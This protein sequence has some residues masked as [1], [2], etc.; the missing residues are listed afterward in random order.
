M[1]IFDGLDAKTTVACRLE[2]YNYAP[3]LSL[4]ITLDDW[5]SE[6]QSACSPIGLYGHGS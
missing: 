4:G 5:L 2:N 3:I 6:A 1:L